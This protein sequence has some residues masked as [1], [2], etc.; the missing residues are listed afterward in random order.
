M[1]YA[2]RNGSNHGCYD[3]CAGVMLLLPDISRG[4]NSFN[5][6]KISWLEWFTI[7]LLWQHSPC[8]IVRCICLQE[9]DCQIVCVC[10][11]GGGGEVFPLVSKVNFWSLVGQ[12]AVR[13]LLGKLKSGPNWSKNLIRLFKKNTTIPY[14]S[15]TDRTVT[16]F[17]TNYF[18]F[19][20]FKYT[21]SDDVILQ[22]CFSSVLSIWDSG[23]FHFSFSAV[24]VSVHG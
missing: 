17:A 20:A 23:R 21:I 12:S 14:E 4:S 2:I 8:T 10:V 9:N 22:T 6:I 11:W 18:F 15:N 3:I 16:L 13:I 5:P 7:E 1:V 24:S 19:F